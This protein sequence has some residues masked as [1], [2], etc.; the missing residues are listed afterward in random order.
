[1]SESITFGSVHQKRSAGAQPLRRARASCRESRFQAEKEIGR[2]EAAAISVSLA[3]QNPYL[4][5]SRRS[6]GDVVTVRRDGVEEHLH[7]IAWRVGLLM[8]WR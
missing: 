4:I 3:D 6:A 8:E 1:M 5:R 7:Q 2:S